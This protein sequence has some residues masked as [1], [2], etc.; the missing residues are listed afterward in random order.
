V[1][2]NPTELAELMRAVATFADALYPGHLGSAILVRVPWAKRPTVIQIPSRHVGALA[3]PAG[4]AADPRPADQSD[5]GQLG[6]P[7]VSGSGRRNEG[8]GVLAILTLNELDKPTSRQQ[9]Y[10]ALLE[11]GHEFS[12]KTFDNHLNRLISHGDIRLIPGRG[13][14]LPWWKDRPA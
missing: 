1:A 5:D 12:R 11:R 3:E 13:L 14:A 2:R 6:P 8:C 7:A 10:T 4:P 9:L